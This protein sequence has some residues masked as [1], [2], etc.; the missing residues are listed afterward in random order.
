MGLTR[1]EQVFTALLGAA[2]VSGLTT[3]ILFLVEATNVLLPADTKFG[4]VFDAGSSHTSLFVYQWLANKENDTGVVSQALACQ[5]KG[6]GISSYASDPAQAG[7]SLQGCLEEA[8]ALIP[9]AKHQQTPMFLGATAGMRLLSQKNSSQAEDVFAAVNRVLSRS[10]VDFWGAEL[11]AGQDEGALGWVTINYVL[12]L[13][14]KLPLLRARPDAEPAPGRAGAEQPGPPGA[15][16]LLPQRLPG[17]AGP[18]RPVRVALHPGR[19]PP[20]PRP[21]PHCGGDGEP[22]GLCRRHPGSL[23]L[24]QLRRPRRLRLRRGLPAPRAGPVLRLLQLLPHVPLPEPHLQAAA[25][26]GQRHCLGV[27]PEALEAGGGELAR[28]GPLAARLLCLWPVR[29]HAPAGGLR[30]QPGDL[31]RHRVPQAGRWHRHRLDARLH[32]E[33]DQLD[34]SRGARPVAGTELWHL[35]GWSRLFGAD[36]HGHSR[37][38]CGAALAPGLGRLP[39]GAGRQRPELAGAFLSPDPQ[40]LP[41]GLWPHGHMAPFCPWGHSGHGGCA[42]AP[43][44][45]FRSQRPSVFPMLHEGWAIATPAALRAV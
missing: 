5:A 6:P 13:L 8:L 45:A 24:L 33:P 27:L 19:G 7:E 15:S 23:Q 44:V 37:G 31:G 35:G 18:G 1:K 38:H 42:V 20:R 4:I 11:L 40:G 2:A 32:A 22:R 10:P 39:A 12:G 9:K 28:A 25:G 41:C 16:P 30:V 26:H 36:P 43:T 34:P 14:V 17:H 21:E 3:L 29:P